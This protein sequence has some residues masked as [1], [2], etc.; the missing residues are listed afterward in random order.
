MAFMLSGVVGEGARLLLLD[1][2]A[3]QASGDA[4]GVGI[5]IFPLFVALLGLVAIVFVSIGALKLPR[6]PT[7]QR[8]APAPRTATAATTTEAPVAATPAPVYKKAP[9]QIHFPMIR[10]GL[11]DV[12]G[13]RE[14]A[15]MIFR[16]EDRA[17]VGQREVAGLTATIGGNV[18]PLVFYRGEARLE[19]TFPA[20][21][22]VTVQVELKVKGETPARRTTRIL[23]VVDYREEIA[24]LF[25]S[26]KETASKS[27]TPLRHDATAWE[28]HDALLDA[29]PDL[30]KTALREVV[31]SFEE[32]KFSN[33]AVGRTTYEK[34]VG[35]LRTLHIAEV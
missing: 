13:V 34:M 1:F 15:I 20:P 2:E 7:R 8:R 21:Q 12:W 9:I 31:S 22:D 35:A 5:P 30:S 28:V 26:F 33:H 16:V 23:R 14:Q 18:V 3:Q 17:L 4:E 10:Q 24:E 27:V 29:K 32:A 25:A 19:R 11:P 6:M